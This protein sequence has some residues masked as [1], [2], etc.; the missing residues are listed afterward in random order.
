MWHITSIPQSFIPRHVAKTLKQEKVI[1]HIA[2]H[3][4]ENVA[5]VSHF[6]SLCYVELGLYDG[7]PQDW[8]AYRQVRSKVAR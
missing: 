2:T 3:D 8:T 1:L 5:P 7:L 4:K 6:A